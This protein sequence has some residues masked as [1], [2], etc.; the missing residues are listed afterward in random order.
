MFSLFGC[1]I[2]MKSYKE[3]RLQ[4]T[5][6]AYADVRRMLLLRKMTGN[7]VGIDYEFLVMLIGS[8]E[9]GKTE[10]LI[11]RKPKKEKK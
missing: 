1:C 4:I 6:E 8:I 5:D 2:T 11:E 10:V 3:I 9:K 7:D